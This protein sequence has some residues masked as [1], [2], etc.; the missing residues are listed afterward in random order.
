MI[1]KNF[2]SLELHPQLFRI[3][4]PTAILGKS[5]L[6]VITPSSYDFVNIV[7]GALFVSNGVY[8]Q[9]PYTFSVILMNVLYRLWL[10]IPVDHAWIYSNHVFVPSPGG[11]LLLFMFKLP[12]IVFDILTSLLIYKCVSL[13]T[14]VK[15][16]AMLAMFVWL[17]NPYLT[18]AI[19]MDG[20]MDIVSTFLVVWGTY[21]FIC[22]RY[23]VSGAVLAVATMARFYPMFLIPF[24]TIFILKERRV[25]SFSLMI[26]AYFASIAAAVIPFVATYGTG[27]LSVLYQ[28]PVG[29]NKE[30]IWF[31]GFRPSGALTSWIE[32]SSVMTVSA[33]LALLMLR[34]WRNDRCLILDV[35]LIVLVTYVG[36]S[37]FNRYYTIWVVPFLTMDLALYWDGAHANVRKA[38]YIIFFL[39]AFVYNGAYWWFNN[40]LFVQEFTPQIADM[41]VFMQEIGGMLRTGELGTTFSQ[42]ILA[43]TCIIYATMV[44]I[45]KIIRNQTQR[46]NVNCS[47]RRA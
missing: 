10:L 22:E 6:A 47:V 46:G 30:F 17:L 24:F 16:L 35:I 34:L 3:I 39:S 1:S 42:S 20:T 41:S 8:F 26:G 37:H 23:V 40:V 9:G 14:T 7:H 29:G 19:E 13:L 21:L 28:L 2:F 32:I 18:I 45:R 38:L 36:L 31:F 4:L 27:F 43:G 33:V 11:Y 5:F 44:A 25:R 12:L 15:Q